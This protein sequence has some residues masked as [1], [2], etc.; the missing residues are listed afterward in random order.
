MRFNISY[1]TGL[2]KVTAYSYLLEE[3][4]GT[5]NALDTYGVRFAGATDIDEELKALYT[6]EYAYQEKEEASGNTLETAYMLIEGGVAVSGITAKLGYEV[7]G[8]DEGNVGFATPLATGHKFNGWADQFLGTP[9]EGLTDLYV[10]FSGKLA[11]G[12]WAVAYH[13]FNADEASATVDDLGSEL[14]L[15]FS[16][17][18]GKNYSAGV[19]YAAYSAGDVAANKV[20]TDKIWLWLGAK[21]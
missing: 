11:G 10:S 19:K 18:F 8:S 5:D 20:D 14:D 4:E 3:D 13:E 21:F 12:K 15:S 7:L 17:G 9:K 1:T 6:L 2:G 16:K